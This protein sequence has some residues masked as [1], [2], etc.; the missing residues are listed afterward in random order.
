MNRTQAIAKLKNHADAIMALGATSLFLFG[1]TARN[2]NNSN[3]DLDLFVGYDPNGKY[4]AAA[5]GLALLRRPSPSPH[6]QNGFR[7][8][9]G[10]TGDLRAPL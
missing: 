9:E 1:S 2:E 8:G 6:A 10:G 5:R 3:S 4:G 7:I